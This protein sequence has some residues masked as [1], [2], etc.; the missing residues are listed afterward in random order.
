[1]C[2]LAH[3]KVI[4]HSQEQ[5]ARCL[6]AEDDYRRLS[7]PRLFGKAPNPR[8]SRQLPANKER[9]LQCISTGGSWLQTTRSSLEVLTDNVEMRRK[10]TL[11][12]PWDAELISDRSLCPV[13]RVCSQAYSPT[14]P[15]GQPAQPSLRPLAPRVGFSRLLTLQSG[16][17]MSGAR[18]LAAKQP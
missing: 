17:C 3:N 15:V 4:L 11:P 8:N 13:C 7:L 5:R 6:V 10:T 2:S 14:L 1:M 12:S 18:L 16:S 9:R